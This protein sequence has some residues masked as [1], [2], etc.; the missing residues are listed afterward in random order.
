MSNVR[1]STS[2]SSPNRLPVW[3]SRVMHAYES[4]HICACVMSHTWISPVAHTNESCHA[5]EWVI[6]HVRPSMLSPR[7]LPMTIRH[8]T[9]AN[10]SCCMYANASCHI[11]ECVI[12]YALSRCRHQSGCLCGWVMLHMQTNHVTYVH[13]SRHTYKWVLWHIWM[14]HVTCA[15]EPCHKYGR[16]S[17]HI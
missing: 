2:M 8:V 11:C 15:N 10:E 16:V 12:C 9:C 1:F 13:A 17:L 3:M 5:Y 6:S 7:R 4:G 14:S